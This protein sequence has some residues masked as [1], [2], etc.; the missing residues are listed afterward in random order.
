MPDK[1]SDPTVCFTLHHGTLSSCICDPPPPAPPLS[2]SPNSPIVFPSSRSF[3]V[4]IYS[5]WCLQKTA[6][7]PLQ[8][9]A[10]ENPPQPL[11]TDYI[12]FLKKNAERNSR[13]RALNECSGK[14][15]NWSIPRN[16][17]FFIFGPCGYNRN[18]FALHCH[19]R[20][21]NPPPPR[22]RGSRIL[23]RGPVEF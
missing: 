21:C 9:N 16:F 19:S 8:Q 4:Y 15:W 6:A 12:F 18:I 2:L 11:H 10:Q 20:G 23:V 1:K 5:S 7:I 22:R 14:S 13:L 3:L 17:C